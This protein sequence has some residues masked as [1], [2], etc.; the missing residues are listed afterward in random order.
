DRPVL[1]K[2]AAQVAAGGSERKDAR[3]GIELVE[4]LFLDRVD[5]KAGAFAI[6]REDHLAVAVFADEAKAAVA[7]PQMTV[8]RTEITD[9]PLG[10]GRV[11]MPPAAEARAI[12]QPAACGR[13]CNGNGH[14]KEKQI[15]SRT[16]PSLYGRL[17][18]M[19]TGC[20][21]AA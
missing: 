6:G 18:E 19:L 16:S 14:S 4:R 9:D 11:L 12:G 1:A 13:G 5:T 2:L 20:A 10:I 15:S 21:P 3:A 8:A 7:G 17:Q